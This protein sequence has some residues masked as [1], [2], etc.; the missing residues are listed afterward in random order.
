MNRDQI[1]AVVMVV[2]AIGIIHST[3]NQHMSLPHSLEVVEQEKAR[4]KQSLNSTESTIKAVHSNDALALLA[5]DKK[6]Q[7][8]YD[9]ITAETSKAE[10]DRKML[11]S[12]LHDMI[13]KGLVHPPE[14]VLSAMRNFTS[15]PE[16]SPEQKKGFEKL[17]R[18]VTKWRKSSELFEVKTKE[19]QNMMA[20]LR[21]ERKGLDSKKQSRGKQLEAVLKEVNSIDVRA[22]P[23]TALTDHSHHHP[24][25]AT[26]EKD[27]HALPI[28]E[29]LKKSVY[30]DGG[31]HETGG[32]GKTG[33]G[34]CEGDFGTTLI[35]RWRDV[36]VDLCDPVAVQAKDLG[37]KVD[38]TKLADQSKVTCRPLLQTQHTSSDVLCT[39]Q[40]VVVNYAP[41]SDEQQT[42][43]VMK[44][45]VDSKHEDQAYLHWKPGLIK[46]SCSKNQNWAQ[47]KFPG[48][49]RD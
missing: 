13:E 6:L 31:E 19:A 7:Q 3:I 37:G 44:K 43:E 5:A 39:M 14:Y 8:S 9:H 23:A 35:Q 10:Q 30:G 24:I 1:T 41:L 32:N 26:A 45:Y 16:G 4:V 17:I 15:V 2:A 42:S 28:S 46:G 34:T 21:S 29:W 20:R 18:A 11:V 25:I 27:F 49:N 47:T 40:N 22:A 38:V 48:W 12:G 33:R 36:P